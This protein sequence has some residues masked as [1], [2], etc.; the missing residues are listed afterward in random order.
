VLD[1][2]HVL[3]VVEA[4]ATM[5]EVWGLPHGTAIVFPFRSEIVRTRSVAK[6]SWQPT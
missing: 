1:D 3:S 6:S 4:I 5:N 2:V